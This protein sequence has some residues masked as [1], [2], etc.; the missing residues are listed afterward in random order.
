[1]F[2]KFFN[3]FLIVVLATS[4]SREATFDHFLPFT[5][6]RALIK[7]LFSD[8]LIYPRFAYT[9]HRS[10]NRKPLIQTKY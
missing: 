7:L 2:E 9:F 5:N 4:V 10:T 6:S 8:N 1:M 3:A